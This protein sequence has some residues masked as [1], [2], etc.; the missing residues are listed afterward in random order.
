MRWTQTLIPTQKETPS[1]AQI[2]SHQLMVRGGIIRQLTAGAY[3]FLPLGFR[4]LRK[5]SQIVREEMDAIGCAEVLL[6]ALQP[7]ELWQKTGRDVTYGENLM[8]FK[9]RH[10]R[11]NVLGPTHEEVVTEMVM[12]YVSSYRQLPLSIYQ[13]QTKFR[14]EYRPRFGLL[15]VREFTMKDAYS[16]HASLESLNEVYDRF[17]AAYQKIFTRC[18]IPFVI[19]EAEAGPIGGSASHEFMASCASGEDTLV[20]SDKNNYAANVEKAEIG[21]RPF[22]FD[23]AATGELEKVHTPGLPGIEDV[24]KF[25]K[26]KPKNMLKTLVFKATGGLV[27]WIVAVVRGDHD[28]NESKLKKAAGEKFGVASIELTDNETVRQQWAIGFVSPTAVLK[29]ERAGLL[30]DPD[31]AQG[32]FWASGANEID[33]HVKHFNWRRE[34]GARLD[35]AKKVAVA[36][37]RNAA[38]GDPSPKNDGG[39]L[40]AS[41]GI[42]IGHVFKLG[43]KYSD[44]LGADFLDEKGEKHPMIMGCYGI[45]VGRILIAAVEAFH[46]DKGMVWPAAIAPYSVI[47]TPIKYDGEVKAAADKL[48]E[49]LNA[50]GIDTLL[51]D[52]DQRPGVKFNDADLI[53]IPVRINIGDRGLKEGKFELKK[54]KAAEAEMVP[55]DALL[56]RI[57]AALRE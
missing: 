31:A 9:D 50:A 14:D 10:G 17:Y 49:Q 53:G 13:I 27:D 45:G 48:Y 6:P 42:E 28:V 26:V 11:M 3:D 15:R 46:D 52:R 20:T 4:S 56:E 33:Y 22:T 32:G 18:G 43:T 24:G 8:K 30:V 21:K 37:I 36:D 41:K 2:V 16:F 51:D 44:A 34:C 5:A 19:V 1:D 57:Q 29:V 12:A 47:I 23:A 25:M 54:R 7:Y 40:I 55:A 39:K 38:A 35:E